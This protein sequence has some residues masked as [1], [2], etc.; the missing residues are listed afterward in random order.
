MWNTPDDI[1]PTS[2]CIL[3]EEANE[4]F[5]NI[6]S[7]SSAWQQ[8]YGDIK[9]NDLKHFKSNAELEDVNPH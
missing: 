5:F 6:D 9:K 3:I 4:F 2:R 8:F 7:L 1:H